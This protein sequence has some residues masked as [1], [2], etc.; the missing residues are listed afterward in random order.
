MNDTTKLTEASKSAEGTVNEPRP[1]ITIE[2]LQRR[3]GIG[4]T[5]AYA[6]AHRLPNDICLRIG[7]KKLLINEPKLIAYLE[8]KGTRITPRPTKTKG[9]R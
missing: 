9:R 6:W 1:W 3:Y 7:A 2:Q 8:Q 5:A 4:R